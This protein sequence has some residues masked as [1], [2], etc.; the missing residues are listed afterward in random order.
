MLINVGNDVKLKDGT[1]GRV[2]SISHFRPP[3]CKYAL[4]INGRDDLTF[5]GDD[6]IE[7]VVYQV[8]TR[9]DGAKVLKNLT[10][11]NCEELNLYWYLAND[12]IEAVRPECNMFEWVKAIEPIKEYLLRKVDEKNE[13]NKSF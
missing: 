4:D 1:I 12:F 13:N 2:A 7:D 8:S 11:N 5:V 3:E 9:I 6:A 10:I